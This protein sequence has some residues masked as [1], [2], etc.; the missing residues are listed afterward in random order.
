MPNFPNMWDFDKLLDICRDR[1]ER[2]SPEYIVF[3]DY[4]SM[5]I[6]L[7]LGVTNIWHLAKM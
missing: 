4:C 2:L 7:A 3:G 6:G 5:V 1:F